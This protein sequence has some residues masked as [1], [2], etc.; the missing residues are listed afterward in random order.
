[1]ADSI[2]FP[3]FFTFRTPLLSFDEWLRWTESAV[4]PAPGAVDLEHELATVCGALRAG[5]Q[6]LIQRPH[7]QEGLFLVSPGLQE[8]IDA[9]IREPESTHG[10]HI[11]RSLIAA[12]SA[13]FTAVDGRGI[14]IA[15]MLGSVAEQT[16]LRIADRATLRRHSRV[17]YRFLLSLVGKR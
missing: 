8:S 15:P 3:D 12:V 1:V 6:E 10:Q 2:P 5:L 17:D 4:R 16:T 11:E 14:A 9:W 13:L 7:V